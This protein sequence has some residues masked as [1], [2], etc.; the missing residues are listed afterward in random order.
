M[1][2]IVE[3]FIKRHKLVHRH[4]TIVVGVSG[5]PDSMALL[6]YL[7]KMKESWGIKIIACCVD[8]MLR[9]G[10]SR[11][12]LE[13]VASFCKR[14]DILFEGK[15][16]NVPQYRKE[17]RIST[18]AA[19]RACRY[20]VFGDVMKR[21]NAA[22]LALAHHGD[23]QI[24][25]ML[26]RQVRGSFGAARAGIPVSRSFMNGKIIRPFLTVTKKEIEK[27]CLE[28]GIQPRVD[29]TNESDEYTRNRFRKV[30]LPFLK[31]ENPQVHLRFQHDS[32]ML[33]DDNRYLDQLAQEKLPDI[34][35]IKRQEQITIAIQH[36]LHTPI[37]L[38]RRII[39]LILNYLYHNKHIEPSLQSIHIETL[40]DWFRSDK[41][42]GTRHLPNQLIAV[43]S[44]DQCTFTFK[45]DHNRHA[46]YE[47]ALA[48][49]GVTQIPAGTITAEVTN[50]VNGYE[51]GL[52]RFICPYDQAE[53]PLIVRSR[54]NGDRIAPKGMSGTQKIKDIFINAKIDRRLREVWPVVVDAN[55]YV[56]WLPLLKHSNKA[57]LDVKNTKYLILTFEP[58]ANF[59]RQA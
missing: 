29:K 33:Y 5:G 28:N 37:P 25:T 58:T 55:G 14:K 6:D 40:L 26:M 59:G 8:H 38:Q 47:K 16:I 27:Y 53:Q 10:D 48:V 36:F 31:A 49:P 12:D 43:R 9:G 57:S 34:V 35:T 3:Q 21:Y 54:Q 11:K 51:K 46:N 39:H 22:A 24:E 23:D 41:S 18:E 13:Y 50:D 17:H 2:H 4:D 44:Y 56:L 15:S 1:E 52:N 20:K 30:I 19:A 45:Q 7:N 42:S 32:E